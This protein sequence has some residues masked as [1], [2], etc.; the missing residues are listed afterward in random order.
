[1]KKIICIIFVGFLT[2]SPTVYADTVGGNTGCTNTFMAYDNTSPWFDNYQ[3]SEYINGFLRIHFRFI[4]NANNQGQNTW[5]PSITITDSGCNIVSEFFVQ[6]NSVIA[7]PAGT[8]NF[9]LRFHSPTHF[10]IWNDDLNQPVTCEVCD[11][12]FANF[13]LGNNLKVNFFANASGIQSYIGSDLFDIENTNPENLKIPV[14]I[15]PGIMGTEIFKGS[16]KLWPD[17]T[18]MLNPFHSDNFMD[19]LAY[20][21]NFEPLD[22]SL[23]IAQVLRKEPFFDYSDGLIQQ[24]VSKGYKEGEDLFTFPYDWRK[25]LGLTAS[26]NLTGQIDYIL[27]QTSAG[28]V[29]GKVNIIAHSQGGLVTKKLLMDVPAYDAKINKLIFVGVPN[30]G[31]PKAAKVL[32]YGDNM[33]ISFASMGLNPDEVKKI[34][35]NM[36]SVYQLLPGR[37]YFKYVN[38]YLGKVTDLG[39]NVPVA[40]VETLNYNDSLQ[41]LKDQG[42]NPALVDIS[43]SFH[44]SA[45]DNFDFSSSTIQAYNIIGCQQPT[46]GKI[47]MR[48]GGHFQIFPT[49]G[50]GTVPIFSADNIPGSSTY[51]ALDSSHASMLSHDGIRDQIINILEGNTA[52]ATAD[53]TNTISQCRF[54]GTAV[55]VHSPVEMHIYDELGRHVGP[56]S[57]GS[58]EVAIKG[59]NYDTIEEQKFAFIPQGHTYTVKLIAIGNGSFDFYSSKI[60]DGTISKSA[61]YSKIPISASS[62]VNIDLNDNNDQTIKLDSDG[63]MVIDAIISPSSIINKNQF[64]DFISPI[65]A[66]RLKG[67]QGE[68]GFFRGEV[69]V[70]LEAGDVII[71]GREGETSGVLKTYYSIDGKPFQ[72][73]SSSTPIWIEH[74]GQHTITYYSIDRAGNSESQQI[75]NFVIDRTPPEAKIVFNTEKLDLDFEGRDNIS[76]P[77]KVKIRQEEN[78]VVLSDQAGNTTE[79]VFKEKSRK[80]QMRAELVAI[81]YNKRE[82]SLVKNSFSYSW[83][84]KPTKELIVLVQDVRAKKDFKIDA[85]FERG[86]TYFSG[87]DKTGKIEKVVPKLVLLNVVTSKGE[88]TWT[89]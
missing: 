53:I 21:R 39:T 11:I 46:L 84:V 57:D 59:A 4:N 26:E 76:T 75:K 67:A 66:V 51:Y 77:N 45:F 8:I 32:L 37:E 68:D 30:L 82:A 62:K 33:D 54:N 64:D 49:A 89:Y 44:N 34:S 79:L 60:L 88:L 41:Y 78:S 70:N 24:L 25:D 55:S 71:E 56:L 83:I 52:N 10:Q 65:T 18:R 43:N 40:H 7:F 61:Y 69:G 38:G 1:M 15:V 58:I 87:R 6:D 20:K 36:P 47:L 48:P 28:K 13:N 19:P 29:T 63:D 31:A 85:T 80:K 35:Q 50:D 73:Y 86:K 27:N 2:L 9:S 42:M 23:N 3:S 74:E 16:E 17:V 14:L 72:T 5:T 22:T 81:K 12:D